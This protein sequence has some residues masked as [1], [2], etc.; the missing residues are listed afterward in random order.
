MNLRDR[1]KLWWIK[2]R[3]KGKCLYLSGTETLKEPLSAEDEQYWIN[4]Y[5]TENSLA[6]RNELIEHNLRLVIYV[7]KKYETDYATLEDLVSI[8]MLG[9]FKA[10]KTFKCDKNIKL[11]TYASRCI[12]NEILM[13]LRK[14]QKRKNEVSFD[15]PLNSD[16]EGNE[17]LLEDIIPSD[18]MAVTEKIDKNNQKEVLLKA[19][20]ELTPREREIIAMRYGLDGM[21][22]MTQKETA[23][24]LGI[25]QSYISR[26][27][28][29]ILK[30]LRLK[31][32]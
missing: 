28:K 20:D 13:F 7:A 2:R 15:E 24:K 26:L 8:G 1:I 19:L 5:I 21:E 31:F 30:K 27:E 18:E 25:S 14:N 29:K 23:E 11:A 32:N 10:I 17:L 9:L 6:A 22:E 16:N 3:W 12:D 4:K